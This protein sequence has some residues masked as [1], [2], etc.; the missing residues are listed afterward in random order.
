MK[1]N[2]VQNQHI[3]HLTDKDLQHTTGN[4]NGRYLSHLITHPCTDETYAMLTALGTT[5]AWRQ[6]CENM[7]ESKLIKVMNVYDSQFAY[8]SDIWN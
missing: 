6:V 4:L 8:D 2:F 5:N 3:M 7:W 1:N